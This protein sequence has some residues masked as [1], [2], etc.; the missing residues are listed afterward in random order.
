[1]L[2]ITLD[3]NQNQNQNQKDNV[4]IMGN[5]IVNYF[6][7]LLKLEQQKANGGCG[8]YLRLAPN[9]ANDGID[10]YFLK[11]VNLTNIPIN[12]IKNI[13]HT[14]HSI[15]HL[16]LDKFIPCNR[17]TSNIKKDVFHVSLQCLYSLL[18][19]NCFVP[20]YLQNINDFIFTVNPFNKS[21]INI[22]KFIQED[23]NQFNSL[24]KQY[25]QYKY[26]FSYIKIKTVLPCILWSR[27]FMAT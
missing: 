11:T 2:K 19:G 12:N 26:T 4:I 21:I 22:N 24:I 18:T 25:E 6:L 10:L 13:I 16:V 15:D 7:E 9:L 5:E 8:K 17:I 14:K 3:Q 23:F 1:V 20:Q 27:H